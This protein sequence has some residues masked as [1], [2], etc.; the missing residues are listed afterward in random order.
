VSQ[1]IIYASTTVLISDYPSW[2]SQTGL[3][4]LKLLKR[5]QSA[6]ITINSEVQRQKQIGYKTFAFESRPIYSPTQVDLTYLISDNSNEILLDLNAS[7]TA[8]AFNNLQYPLRDRNLFFFISDEWFDANSTSNQVDIT[9]K[10]LISVGNCFLDNYS[11]SASIGS[12][13]SVQVSFSALN[14]KFDNYQAFSTGPITGSKTPSI[15]ITGGSISTGVYRLSN[16]NFNTSNYL[17]NQNSRPSGLRPGDITLSL[18]QPI[19]G[20]AR[21]SGSKTANISSFQISVP[22][23]RKDLVGFGSNYPYDK[24]LMFPLLGTLSMDGIADDFVTGNYNNLFSTNENY[25]MEFTLNDCESNKAIVFG[26]QNARLEKQSTSV[27]LSDQM[28]FQAEFSF[29]VTQDTGFTISGA[30]RLSDSLEAS[31]GAY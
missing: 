3:F 1:R 14:T 7:G 5:V 12:I 22:L 10:Q 21:L 24:K 4:S 19:I 17:T 28:G 27:G 31:V 8:C 15:D 16:S 13:P 11:I 6:S 2:Q 30:A 23:E 9:D 18:Q 29:A 26:V 20:G 25:D